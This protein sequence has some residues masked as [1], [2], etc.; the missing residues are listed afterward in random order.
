MGRATQAWRPPSSISWNLVTEFLSFRAV[1]GEREQKTLQRD[2]V[3]KI[4]H[5]VVL[6]VKFA[7]NP[8]GV[9]T[10]AECPPDQVFS[11]DDI[12]RVR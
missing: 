4:V 10:V 12:D 7:L 5:C 11:L 1:F 3:L 9:V 8:G 6:Y 2:A